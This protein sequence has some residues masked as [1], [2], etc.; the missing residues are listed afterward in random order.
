VLFYW[1]FKL[2]ATSEAMYQQNGAAS[3]L[4]AFP[5]TGTA[6]NLDLL[7]IVGQGGQ[8]LSVVNYQGTVL[9]PF[10]SLAL[11]SISIASFVISAV[12]STGG[13]STYTGTFTGASSA[14]VGQK[15]VI[16]G[17]GNAGNNGT[18]VIT[19][20]N[21]TTLVV[22]NATPGANETHAGTA[23]ITGVSLVTYNG[24]ITGGG[25]NAFAGYN[26]S[27]NGFTNA[28]N[29]ISNTNVV[30]STAATLVTLFALQIAETDAATVTG[31]VPATLGTRIGKFS[32]NLSNSASIAAL[33]ASAF[34]NPSL[35]DIVQVRNIGGTISYYLNYQGVATGS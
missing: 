18:F 14:W 12:S 2:T 28:A 3:V 24:S 15:A 11:T 13:S 30:S 17:M 6:Q 7:Q 27:V 8:T 32:T 33:Y 23:E 29:N 25:S 16:A 21:T 10:G 35:Q 26:I 4:T 5:N 31:T 20:A 22:T 34:D 9:G 19:S 1:R